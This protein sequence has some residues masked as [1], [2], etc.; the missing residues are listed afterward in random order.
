MFISIF[1]MQNLTP[2]LH[3]KSV[4]NGLIFRCISMLFDL[5]LL[6]AIYSCVFSLLTHWLFSGELSLNLKKK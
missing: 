3:K 1:V 5:L 6:F 2:V 4:Y